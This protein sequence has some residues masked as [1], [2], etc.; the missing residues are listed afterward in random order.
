MNWLAPAYTNIEKPRQVHILKSAFFARIPKVIAT[1][2]NPRIKGTLLIQ[3]SL[4]SLQVYF[5]I[6]TS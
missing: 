6:I 4:I 3:P 5:D 2:M 1:G